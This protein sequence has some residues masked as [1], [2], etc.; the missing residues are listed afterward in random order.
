MDPSYCGRQNF[1]DGGPGKAFSLAV[2]AQNMAAA[3]EAERISSQ[4]YPT[5]AFSLKSTE[6]HSP[7][8]ASTGVRTAESTALRNGMLP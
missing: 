7:G 5:S 6:I 8:H 1:I 2:A 3:I 4:M